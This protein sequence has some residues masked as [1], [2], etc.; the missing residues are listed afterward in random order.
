MSTQ[1]QKVQFKIGGMACS[2]CVASITKALSRMDEVR[3][4][5]VNLAHE[6]TLVEYEPTKLGP[7]KL[8]ETLLDLGYTAASHIGGSP[9]V[10][11]RVQGI[12]RVRHRG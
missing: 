1:T 9:P 3:D 6:E 8:K 5:N 12:A 2:F 11:S 10:L 7:A 4:V